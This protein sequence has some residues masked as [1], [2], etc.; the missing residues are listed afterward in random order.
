MGSRVNEL[1]I[2]ALGVQR[3]F[4]NAK[5]IKTALTRAACLI[6]DALKNHC[7]ILLCGNGG[8][9]ADA[10][11]IAAEL[12]GRFKIERVGL[13]AIALASNPSVTTAVANDYGA[14]HIFRRQVVAFGQPGDILIAYSTSGTSPNVMSAV[15]AAQ[16]QHLL[17]IA[18]TGAKGL[19]LR[20]MA[21]VCIMAPST[22]TAR[23]QECHAVAGHIICD[24][25]ER[26]LMASA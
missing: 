13:P 4:A 2:E 9:A 11:H 14:D 10:Q 5:G 19:T 26:D 20:N 3:K 23:I 21:D 1:L 18:M 15:E 22:D 7:K 17:I 25:V 6:S 8:S 12:V 24:L 16:R